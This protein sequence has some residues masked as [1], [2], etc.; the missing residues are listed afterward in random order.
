MSRPLVSKKK[1]LV[2]TPLSTHKRRGSRGR[3]FCHTPGQVLG[4]RNKRLSERTSERAKESVGSPSPSKNTLSRWGREK[5]PAAEGRRPSAHCSQPCEPNAPAHAQTPKK[6]REGTREGSFSALTLDAMA[7]EARGAE[8]K[9]SE[10]GGGRERLLTE[11]KRRRRKKNS[12]HSLDDEL[13]KLSFILFHFS[14]R[15]EGGELSCY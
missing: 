1:H 2:P 15:G 11:V 10:A 13:R 14:A 4:M 7:L 5:R 8:K 12:T 9:P 6:Q 3:S